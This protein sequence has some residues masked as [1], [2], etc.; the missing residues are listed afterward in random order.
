MAASDP[1]PSAQARKPR[2]LNDLLDEQVKS[3]VIS[4]EDLAKPV[5]TGSSRL[6]P[7]LPPPP[8]FV[9]PIWRANDEKKCGCLHTRG[10]SQQGRLLS[11]FRQRAVQQPIV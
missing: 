8:L 11:A 2:S 1:P 4:K 9:F 5:W 6:I 3:G 7:P 10:E